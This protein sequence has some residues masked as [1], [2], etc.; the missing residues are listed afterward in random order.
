M[1]PSAFAICLTVALAG[2]AHPSMVLLPDE[3]GGH[4]QVAILESGGKTTDTVVSEANSRA[5]L[6]ASQPSVKALGARGLKPQEAALVGDLPPP[7]KSFTLYFL[8][9][10]TE[11]TPESLPVLDELR[12]EIAKRP[13]AEVQVTG[14]TDTVGSDADN[15]ALSQKRAEEILNWLVSRGFDRSIMSA[16]GRGE[17]ELKEPTADNV[18]SPANRRVEVI[19]R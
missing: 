8:E 7:A 14:H 11:V 4:G 5:S 19:V 18:G 12:A 17:R 6:G 3:D 10:T 13:G 15:D 9:G 1:K 16:V 2:C